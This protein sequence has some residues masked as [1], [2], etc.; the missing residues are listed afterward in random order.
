[1]KYLIVLILLLSTSVIRAAANPL[2][3]PNLKLWEFKDGCYQ[4]LQINKFV[5]KN[6]RYFFGFGETASFYFSDLNKNELQARNISLLVNKYDDPDTINF[7]YDLRA[8]IFSDRGESDLLENGD[9][10]YRFDG[11]I[12]DAGVNTEIHLT[13]S[14]LWRELGDDKVFVRIKRSSD[15]DFSFLNMKHDAILLRLPANHCY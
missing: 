1:M 6:Q 2:D 13:Q 5:F 4:L 3:H 11:Q 14:I 15:N 12:F 9:L 7:I 10:F 8:D